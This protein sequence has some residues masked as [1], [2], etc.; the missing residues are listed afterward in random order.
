[1][2]QSEASGESERNFWYHKK[3]IPEYRKAELSE[4]A[5]GSKIS[6]LHVNASCRIDLLKVAAETFADAFALNRPFLYRGEFTAPAEEND[7]QRSECFL[8]SDGL[9]GFAVTDDQWLISLFSNENWNGFMK[10]TKTIVT[11]KAD[12]LVCIVTGEYRNSPLIKAYENAYGFLPYARTICDE[13]IMR[14]Y[15]GNDFVNEFILHNGI[16][17]HVFLCRPAAEQSC[18]SV[19]IF[20]NY[21]EAK[22][23]INKTIG[24]RLT[25]RS[26]NHA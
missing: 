24:S 20:D 12:K 7:Y 26:S 15:Y 22:E 19:Q 4:I 11:G 18:D 25:E 5:A 13:K 1:M 21:Y 17:Y 23:W 8:T 16:P 6:T 9:A 3:S 14:E 10:L 2:N